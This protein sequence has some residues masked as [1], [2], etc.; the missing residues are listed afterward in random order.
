MKWTP[1]IKLGSLASQ[2]D[3][4]PIELP[5]PACRQF[6]SLQIYFLYK[7]AQ[8]KKVWVMDSKTK[9]LTVWFSENS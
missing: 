8:P 1:G 7:I 4:R 2:A 6:N 9:L 5:V 3:A